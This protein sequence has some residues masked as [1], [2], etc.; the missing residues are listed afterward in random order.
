MCEIFTMIK[1]NSFYSIELYRCLISLGP[2]SSVGAELVATITSKSASDTFI[3]QNNGNLMLTMISMCLAFY[4]FKL[5]ANL[6]VATS[7]KQR[8]AKVCVDSKILCVNKSWIFFLR[9]QFNF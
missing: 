7:E 6:L 2:A 5:L 3:I 4:Y 1:K 9:K 8:G